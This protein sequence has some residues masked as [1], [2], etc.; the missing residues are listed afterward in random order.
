MSVPNLV[1]CDANKS[2]GKLTWGRG[3]GPS[4]EYRYFYGRVAPQ[5]ELPQ[6]ER[7]FTGFPHV[8]T[9]F[10]T[11]G[12]LVW[13]VPDNCCSGMSGH[14]RNPQSGYEIVW[15]QVYFASVNCP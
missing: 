10:T 13:P 11:S 7:E 5:F 8:E 6:S 3:G 2:R 15:Q 12:T 1:W 4:T 14:Y 9:Y